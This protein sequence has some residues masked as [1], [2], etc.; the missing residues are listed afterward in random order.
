MWLALTAGD[1]SSFV[2]SPLGEAFSADGREW[3][4]PATAASAESRA[5]VSRAS[6]C[7]NLP[8]LHVGS[9]LNSLN[10]LDEAVGTSQCMDPLADR[11]PLDIGQRLQ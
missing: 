5:D 8:K 11:A 7:T 2:G 10:E 6:S 9:Y 4:A 3:E 1:R